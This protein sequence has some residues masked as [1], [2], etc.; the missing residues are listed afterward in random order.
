MKI[1]QTTQKVGLPQG[2]MTNDE[3]AVEV[4]RQFWQAMIDK[5]FAKAS[6][7]YEG[8]PVAML[9]KAFAD[10]SKG[11]LLEIVS[12]GPVQPHWM[13]KTGG[14]NVPCTI[15]IEKD[16]Q[17]VEQTFDKIGVRQVRN[18]PGLWTIFGGL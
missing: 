5:D 13:P 12:V 3:V 6:Q 4:V 14:V 11:K 8:I 16:G 7:M 18:Q 2:A 10:S 1:D 9:E 17:V 15:K